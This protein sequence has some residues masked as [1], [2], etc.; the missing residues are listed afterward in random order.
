ME[1]ERICKNVSIPLDFPGT[2]S[3]CCPKF[4]PSLDSFSIHQVNYSRNV[5]GSVPRRAEREGGGRTATQHF[6]QLCKADFFSLPSSQLPLCDLRSFPNKNID[7]T[8]SKVSA[9][10]VLGIM[11]N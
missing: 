1:K 11:R 10:N 6:P 3:W 2:P 8:L 5:Q 4:L 9:A 7:V